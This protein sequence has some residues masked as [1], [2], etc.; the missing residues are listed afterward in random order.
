MG[1][2]MNF[3][4]FLNRN[5]AIS[6]FLVTMLF[7]GACASNENTTDV[8][9]VETAQISSASAALSASVE[10]EDPADVIERAFA[11]IDAEENVSKA[12]DGVEA[13]CKGRFRSCK[14]SL[15]CCGRMTCQYFASKGR[16]CDYP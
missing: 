6:I 3:F 15:D 8:D 12:S 7:I 16:R 13:S 9:P 4:Q 10:S 11:M 14:L 2:T 5:I 1:R